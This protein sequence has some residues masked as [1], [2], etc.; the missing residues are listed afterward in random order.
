MIQL[1]I[2]GRKMYAAMIALVEV[3]HGA[4][5]PFAV[6][7][8]QRSHERFINAQFRG[9]DI[10]AKCLFPFLAEKVSHLLVHQGFQ[11]FLCPT[12]EKGRAENAA[13]KQHCHKERFECL[14]LQH[15]IENGTAHCAN[16]SHPEPDD[17]HCL[18]MSQLF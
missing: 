5:L 18:I 4:L 12:A 11:F 6:Q 9:V 10:R 17:G 14:I 2:S 15:K 8:M 1:Y 3:L 16:H 13:Q 7:Q